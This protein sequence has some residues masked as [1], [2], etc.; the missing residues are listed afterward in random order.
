M[1]W[2]PMEEDLRDRSPH[3]NHGSLQGEAALHAAGVPGDERH[4]PDRVLWLLPFDP[5]DAE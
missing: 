3:G 1:A 2:L 5:G 4:A